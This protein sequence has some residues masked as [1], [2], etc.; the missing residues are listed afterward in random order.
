MLKTGDTAERE[1]ASR[2]ETKENKQTNKV[3]LAC[4]VVCF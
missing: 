4:F 2:E 3:A 1:V